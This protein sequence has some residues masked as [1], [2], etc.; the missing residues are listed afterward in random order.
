MVKTPTATELSCIPTANAMALI[1]VVVLTVTGPAYSV[2]TV[3]LGA[4]PS[5][6]Y[7]MDAPGVVV[8]IVTVCALAKAFGFGL[9]TGVATRGRGELCPL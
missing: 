4:E 8:V 7:L 2:P 5:V 6:V 3:S 1:F 9:K